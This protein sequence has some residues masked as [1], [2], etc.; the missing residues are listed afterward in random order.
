MTIIENGCIVNTNNEGIED[1]DTYCQLQSYHRELCLDVSGQSA[2]SGTP[3]IGWECTGEWNQLFKLHSN[4]TISTEQPEMYTKIRDDENKNITLCLESNHMGMIITNECVKPLNV[5]LDKK[6]STDSN[7][8][9]SIQQLLQTFFYNKV[10]N[11]ITMNISNNTNNETI[12]I[13]TTKPT[14]NPTFVPSLSKR[15]KNYDDVPSAIRRVMEM[16]DQGL[17]DNENENED[18]DNEENDDTNENENVD[19]IFTENNEN[20]GMNEIVE[21]EQKENDTQIIQTTNIESEL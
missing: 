13:E 9:K 14:Q 16:E 11:T 4:C 12:I 20:I 21:S 1:E 18:E 6:L 5:S 3:L 19:A 17:L 15:L 8:D 10:N 2:R 7:N